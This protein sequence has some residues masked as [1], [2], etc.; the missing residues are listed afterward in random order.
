[1]KLIDR[2][3]KV[4]DTNMEEIEALRLISSHRTERIKTL[5][6]NTGLVDELLP[7][8]QFSIE[9][10]LDIIEI[11]KKRGN[12]TVIKPLEQLVFTLYIGFDVFLREVDTI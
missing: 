6:Q 8:I 11:E 2:I 7:G 10:V 4:V 5:S 12:T 9:S 1:M 3:L